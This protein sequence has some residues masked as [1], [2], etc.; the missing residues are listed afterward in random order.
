M[1]TTNLNSSNWQDDYRQALK[2]SA[3]LEQFFGIPFKDTHYPIFLPLHLAKKIKAQGL[4]SV[5]GKQFL[6]SEEELNQQGLIDPIG[7]QVH[8]KT[9]QLIHRYHNRA[10]FIPTQNCPVICRY[11]FRKNELYTDEAIFKPDLEE[12]KNYLLAHPEIEEIIF[13]GGDPFMITNQKINSY[14]EFFSEISSIKYIRFHTRTPVTMPSR[15]DQE[16]VEIL[17]K[18]SK[19]FVRLLVMIHINHCDELGLDEIS[20]IKKMTASHI[21]L[22][23]Q[24]VLL[25]NIN[26]N[27]ETLYSLFKKLIDLKITPY[28]LHHPDQV[29]GG[30]HFSLS[31]EEGRKI[32]Q[33]LRDLLSGWALPEYIIDIPGGF[34]KTSAYNPETFQFSG[35]LI[36]KSGEHSHLFN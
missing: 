22:L 16:L 5:L 34:G 31:L 9:K 33:P 32:Y 13:T 3:A 36:N 8:Q 19:K 2:S 17:D 12:T 26:D 18:Y 25:K 30:M 23:S 10:L 11:C 15:I 21:E 7:D 20:T 29:R 27:T 35:S 14:L 1:E 4:N 24:T 28:Y 6:P